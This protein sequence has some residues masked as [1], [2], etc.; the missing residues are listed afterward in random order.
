MRREKSLPPVRVSSELRARI[1]AACR[2]HQRATDERL[3]AEEARRSRIGESAEAMEK[4]RIEADEPGITH[5]NWAPDGSVR[6][7]DSER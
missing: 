3:L 6:L 2:E 5:V 1:E 4:L 7:D